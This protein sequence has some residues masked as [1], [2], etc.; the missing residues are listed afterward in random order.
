MMDEITYFQLPPGTVLPVIGMEPFYI[1]SLGDPCENCHDR[2]S[3][4]W[5]VGEG[6]GL[7][8]AHGMKAA[9]CER[10]CV[11]AQLKY[12][13]D[14]AARIPDLEKKLAELSEEG[15]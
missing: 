4:V 3:T 15:K 13:Q 6:G 1:K 9:W 10:C 5:W 11:E 12:A 2:I 8:Y 14:A 7:A